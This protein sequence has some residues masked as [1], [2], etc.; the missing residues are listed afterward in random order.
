MA[1]EQRKSNDQVVRELSNINGHNEEFET[2]MDM[3]NMLVDLITS[4]SN[5]KVIVAVEKDKKDIMEKQFIL[6]K[7]EQINPNWSAFFTSLRDH[8]TILEKY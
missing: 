6:R 8:K 1:K 2:K 4:E 7:Y 5:K 3:E